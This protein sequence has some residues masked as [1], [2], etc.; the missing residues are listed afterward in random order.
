M[1]KK[2]GANFYVD[3]VNEL[4]HVKAIADDVNKGILDIDDIKDERLKEALKKLT[5]KSTR[6]INI[7]NKISVQKS[8]VES[9][10]KS[11]RIQRAFQ[12]N[13]SDVASAVR[14]ALTLDTGVYPTQTLVKNILDYNKIPYDKNKYNNP[15]FHKT[16]FEPDVVDSVLGLTK[17][18][19]NTVYKAI[20]Q[21]N[22][23]V[24]VNES[25]AKI[26]INNLNKNAKRLRKNDFVAIA[27]PL[28]ADYEKTEASN[29]YEGT[30]MRADFLMYRNSSS[31][32]DYE[33]AIGEIF[34]LMNSDYN[35]KMSKKIMLHAE[36]FLHCYKAV[37]ADKAQDEKVAKD[38]IQKCLENYEPYAN[39]TG[40]EKQQYEWVAINDTTAGETN[41][42]AIYNLLYMMT[43]KLGLSSIMPK[44]KYELFKA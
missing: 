35:L 2:I 32:R 20:A 30:H 15:V 33:Y 34:S 17:A 11:K 29:P 12:A 23:N 14:V 13:P 38:I 7:G 6:L 5:V 24:K 36:D 43:E 18:N 9:A 3:S 39:A 40:P 44:D 19:Y 27:E 21:G 22:H 42:D 26:A 41:L 4:N 8:A 31:K 25:L 37:T 10:S 1:I 16:E 28:K